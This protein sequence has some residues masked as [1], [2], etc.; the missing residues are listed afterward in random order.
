MFLRLFGAKPP[1]TF[2]EFVKP[3]RLASS[4]IRERK[5]AAT[6]SLKYDTVTSMMQKSE[7]ITIG[8]QCKL[9]RI[10]RRC[11]N[12]NDSIFLSNSVTARHAP[13]SR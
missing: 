6:V 4:R 13:L 2:E 11:K 3:E 9:Y 10:S 8:K 1:P 5:T 12:S 7:G